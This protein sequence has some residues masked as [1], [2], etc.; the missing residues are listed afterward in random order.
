MKRVDNAAF[1]MAHVAAI[2]REGISTSAYAKQHGLAVKTLYGWQRKAN[3]AASLPSEM[4]L[5]P[6]FVALRVADLSVDAPRHGCALILGSGLRL[7][8]LALPSPQWL[9]ALSRAAQGVG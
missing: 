8:M 3:A 4:R 9:A 6:S 5:Q 1:W 2:K 7:E